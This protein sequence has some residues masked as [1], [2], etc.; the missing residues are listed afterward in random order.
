MKTENF[1]F[2]DEN[3]NYNEPTPEWRINNGNPIR[4]LNVNNKIFTNGGIIYYCTFI[5]FIISSIIFTFVGQN[6]PPYNSYIFFGTMLIHLSTI[7]IFKNTKLGR[8]LNK[9]QYY[10]ERKCRYIQ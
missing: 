5:I 4:H 2:E 6:S 7:T 9:K 3:I 10:N 8:W 1:P